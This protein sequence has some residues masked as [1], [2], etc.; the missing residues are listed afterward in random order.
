M[1]PLQVEPSETH[2]RAEDDVYYMLT[3]APTERDH[4]ILAL[5]LDYTSMQGECVFYKGKNHGKYCSI[6]PMYTILSKDCSG[7]C[8]VE[9]LTCLIILEYLEDQ[10]KAEIDGTSD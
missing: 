8:F 7:R 3:L 5:L 2:Q 6:A 1:K 9:G 4:R 10:E